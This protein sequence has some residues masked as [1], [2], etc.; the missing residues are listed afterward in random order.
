MQKL[1]FI[2]TAVTGIPAVM[3]CL[4]E[5]VK[6]TQDSQ[7]EVIVSHCLGGQAS[8]LISDQ[9]PSVLVVE[10]SGRPGIPFLRAAGVE[11]ATSEVVAFVGEHYAPDRRWCEIVS[12]L[13]GHDIDGVGG[14]IE[15]SCPR[16]LTNWPVYLC[17]YSG[18]MLPSD[19]GETNGLAGNNC[20]YRRDIFDEQALES[21][22]SG[23]EFFLQR[24]LRDRGVHLFHEPSMVVSLKRNFT[25]QR[26]LSIRFDFSR[27]F[28]AMRRGRLGSKALLYAAL[29]PAL[30]PVM[31]WRISTPV[32]AK[33]RYRREF[34][35]SSP[36]IAFFCLSAALG[37]AAGYLAGFGASLGNVE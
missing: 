22:R 8:Q 21:L 37:E 30:A 4:T 15:M 26:F 35:L 33:R 11:R 1:T 32:F 7:H 10:S 17:E 19:R 23:W 27:S 20:A 16:T 6:Q 31:F 36:L 34:V 12:E 24:E 3:E 9:Y 14:P 25:F 2:V 18:L 28:A 13:F 29:A 5:L